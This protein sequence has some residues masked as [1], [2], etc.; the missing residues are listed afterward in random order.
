[1][2]PLRKV[3]WVDSGM[4]GNVCRRSGRGLDVVDGLVEEVGVSMVVVA[5]TAIDE[6]KREIEIFDKQTR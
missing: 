2:R 1:M 4:F 3:M 5:G 6:S